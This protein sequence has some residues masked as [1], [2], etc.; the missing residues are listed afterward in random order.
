LVDGGDFLNRE[1]DRGE[2]ESRLIW[3]NME[4]VKYD[5]LTLGEYELGQLDLVLQLMEKTS[6][7]IV[8]TNVEVQQGLNWVPLGEKSRVVEIHGV[9][10]GFISLIT[11]T[12]ASSAALGENASRIRLLP[13]A[14]EAARVAREL[15]GRADLVVLLA[16]VDGKSME[17]YASAMPFV[18]AVIGG[19][20]TLKDEGPIAVGDVVVNRS[21]TRGQHI[22]STRLIVSP[23]GGVVDFGGINVTLGPGFREDSAVV[24]AVTQVKE[25]AARVRQEKMKE[26]RERLEQK[27]Q[28]RQA[29]EPAANQPAT[30]RTP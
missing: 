25:E 19:H 10:V 1:R 21:G 30:P 23:E 29:A 22:C 16:H 17:E 7:P 2:A 26:A 28:E 14:E 6:L 27:A 11:E 8:C 20:V 4:D 5:A 9:R 12:E 13:A 24:A 3:R 18:D 15:R